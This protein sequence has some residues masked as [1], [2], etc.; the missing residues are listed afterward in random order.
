MDDSG[1]WE[2]VNREILVEA[3]IH[4]I[5]IIAGLGVGRS[6]VTGGIFTEFRPSRVLELPAFYRYESEGPTINVVDLNHGTR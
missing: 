1:D 5:F 4:E 6:R 2:E 3:D